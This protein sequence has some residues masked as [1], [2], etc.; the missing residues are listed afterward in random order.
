MYLFV[1][2]S[3]DIRRLIGLVLSFYFLVYDITEYGRIETTILK[4][5][6]N[7]Q[8]LLVLTEIVKGKIL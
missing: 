7:F 1:S 3:K 6:H 2:N 5:G 4:S 8:L